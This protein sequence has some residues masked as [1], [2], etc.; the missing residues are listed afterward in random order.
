MFPYYP[1]IFVSVLPGKHFLLASNFDISNTFSYCGMSI[2]C[3]EYGVAVFVVFDCR[4]L[5]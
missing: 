1:E 2:E 3:E 5:S 4:K